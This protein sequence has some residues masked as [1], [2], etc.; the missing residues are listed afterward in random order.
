MRA[1]PCIQLFNRWSHGKDGHGSKVLDLPQQD[2][3]E[4]SSFPANGWSKNF[5]SEHLL[6]LKSATAR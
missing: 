3:G 4:P 6:G 5:R 1:I 2:M